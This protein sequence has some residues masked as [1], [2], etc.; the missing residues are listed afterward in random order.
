MGTRF[1]GR[2]SSTSGKPGVTAG[3]LTGFYLRLLCSGR[4]VFQECEHIGL[5]HPAILAAAWNGFRVEFMFGNQLAH[6]R[7]HAR[8]IRGCRRR[9]PAGCGLRRRI[10]RRRLRRSTRRNQANHL[11]C[12]HGITVIE[13]NFLKHPVTGCRHF[14]HDLVRFDIN[15]R[16][17][18]LDG[19]AGLLVPADHDAVTDR[20]RQLGYLDF[21][22][23]AAPR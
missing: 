13:Q 2:S 18:T 3:G 7:P 16:L 9:L 20:F 6:G 12:N 10:G 1:C 14:Q 17:V 19:V 4:A 8:R 23:H 22:S 11:L 5:G 21:N 15:Q